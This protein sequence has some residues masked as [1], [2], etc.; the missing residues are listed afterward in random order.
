MYTQCESNEQ[1]RDSSRDTETEVLVFENEQE[2]ARTLVRLIREDDAVAGAVI[3]A[4]L[5]CPNIV[6]QY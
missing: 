3:R 6:R 4:A 1:P 2:L 5:S